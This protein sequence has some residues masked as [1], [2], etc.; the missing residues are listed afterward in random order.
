LCGARII[1]FTVTKLAHQRS[2]VNTTV[3]ESSIPVRNANDFA[4]DLNALRLTDWQAIAQLDARAFVRGC[5][6]LTFIIRD[7]A[8]I[9]PHN[10]SAC[11]DCLRAFTHAVL[12]APATPADGTAAGDQQRTKSPPPLK[13]RAGSI[14]RNKSDVVGEVTKH[15]HDDIDAARDALDQAPHRLLELC[16]TLHVR[17]AQIIAEYGTVAVLQ[18]A[19]TQTQLRPATV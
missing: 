16:Y 3:A 19:R 12:Q 4:Y 10:L 14:H 8:H 1:F 5:D 9:T 11:I 7:T 15:D 13:N 18:C 2:I 6:T 17:S